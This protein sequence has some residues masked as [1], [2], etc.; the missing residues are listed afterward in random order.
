MQ[1]VSLK[2]GNP[3]TFS[4]EFEMLF[5]LGAGVL[6]FS[7]SIGHFRVHA[8]LHFKV[9]LSA[10]SLLWKSVFIHIEIGTNYHNK[11]FALRLAL[12]ERLKGTR[13]WPINIKSCYSI[14]HFC[15]LQPQQPHTKHCCGHKNVLP[16]R[17]IHTS[18]CCWERIG[19]P[20]Q[21]LCFIFFWEKR[22]QHNILNRKLAVI[23]QW[24]SRENLQ[25]KDRLQ[26]NLYF[27]ST[28]KNFLILQ[29]NYTCWKYPSSG[30]YQQSPVHFNSPTSVS[31]Q[32]IW[33]LGQSYRL[34]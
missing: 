31:L 7:G 6:M 4:Q 9:R 11:N 5:A 19:K 15:C 17:W 20:V 32:G 22:F 8:S 13:K 10:K 21:I 33:S 27:S 1:T 30:P 3:A 2:Y 23:H 34:P 14:N 12:K 24:L 25:I 28:I 26:W 29:G 16:L 18:C